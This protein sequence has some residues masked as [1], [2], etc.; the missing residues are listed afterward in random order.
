MSEGQNV[1]ARVLRKVRV[2]NTANEQVAVLEL[3]TGSQTD[4]LAIPRTE[5]AKIA[6]L[7]S[8]NAA[9]PSAADGTAPDGVE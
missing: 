4:Y 7:L 2:L 9:D 1:Q 5:L 3:N 6:N 8:K